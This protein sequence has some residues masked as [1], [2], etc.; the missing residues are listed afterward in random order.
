MILYIPSG[1]AFSNNFEN[2]CR[3]LMQLLW[4]SCGHLYTNHW[5][6]LATLNLRSQ[7][8]LVIAHMYSIAKMYD[9]LESK[10]LSALS[11]TLQVRILNILFTLSMFISNCFS[12]II[13]AF[14]VTVRCMIKVIYSAGTP[15]N[16]VP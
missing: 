6:Q 8:G 1:S 4:H 13:N 10:E 15:S 16:D 3:R 14:I 9:L 2:H 11:H 7:Y 12:I 5:E